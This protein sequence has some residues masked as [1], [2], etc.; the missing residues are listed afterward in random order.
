MKDKGPND[1]GF[2][3]YL[4]LCILVNANF[5]TLV[6]I[7]CYIFNIDLKQFSDSTTIIGLFTGLSIM[8]ICFLQFFMKRKSIC[9]KYDQLTLKR[10]VIGKLVF[11]IYSILSLLIMFV[12][13]ISLN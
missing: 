8:T 10:R 5:L 3:S 4:L 1:Q 2:Y 7:V 11:W 12:L 13:G 9:L 6:M